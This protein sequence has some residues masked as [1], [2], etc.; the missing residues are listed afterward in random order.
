MNMEMTKAQGCN[1]SVYGQMDSQYDPK[2]DLHK[3]SPRDSLM[4][5]KHW[6]GFVATSLSKSVHLILERKFSCDLVESIMQFLSFP[7]FNEMFFNLNMNGLMKQ[8]YLGENTMSYKTFV[9]TLRF[10]MTCGLIINNGDVLLEI[11]PPNQTVPGVV[12]IFVENGFINYWNGQILKKGHKKS[13]FVHGIVDEPLSGLMK[14]H[15]ALILLRKHFGHN[16]DM[17]SIHVPNRGNLNRTQFETMMICLKMAS[18]EYLEK[19]IYWKVDPIRKNR[20]QKIYEQVVVPN[21]KLRLTDRFKKTGTSTWVIPGHQELRTYK[22]EIPELVETRERGRQVAELGDR[23]H[24]LKEEGMKILKRLRELKSLIKPVTFETARL[25]FLENMRLKTERRELNEKGDILWEEYHKKKK[26]FEGHEGDY[27][28]YKEDWF[29][30]RNIEEWVTIPDEERSKSY[31]V[32]QKLNTKALLRNMALYDVEISHKIV[33]E[34]RGFKRIQ[35]WAPAKPKYWRSMKL[36]EKEMQML[37]VSTKLDKARKY[38]KPGKMATVVE[39]KKAHRV[40]K[41]MKF[42]KSEVEIVSAEDASEV[43]QDLTN[44]LTMYHYVQIGGADDLLKEKF[45]S[46]LCLLASSFNEN[47]K[48]KRWGTFVE[49]RDRKL[50]KR[51]FPMFLR[52]IGSKLED[53]EEHSES[54]P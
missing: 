31:S 43:D 41:T 42:I 48:I 28:F 27:K 38:L 34:Q 29:T 40:R 13:S 11:H 36:H 18:K 46:S 20:A 49:K 50:I 15:K 24:F 26:E 2:Y 21:M 44:F 35:Y 47:A 33:T 23:V 37:G 53:F 10:N 12:P 1:V 4:I 16:G 8:V 30:F 51:S 19:P 17:R 22:R 39:N 14:Y 25:E 54:F 32:D 7:C 3:H 52:M 6:P 45:D 9:E 5:V